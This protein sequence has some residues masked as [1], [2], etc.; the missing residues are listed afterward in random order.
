MGYFMAK[1]V[2]ALKE[3]EAHKGSASELG[4]KRLEK[5][6]HHKKSIHGHKMAHNAHEKKEHKKK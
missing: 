5:H 3:K 2:E 1:K 4:A 6:E